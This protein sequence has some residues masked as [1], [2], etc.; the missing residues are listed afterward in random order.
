MAHLDP[1][2]DPC[3]SKYA[4]I[5]I[6]YS[7]NIPSSHAYVDNDLKSPEPIHLNSYD[8]ALSVIKQYI[9]QCPNQMLKILP[10][11]PDCAIRHG[12]CI[13]SNEFYDQICSTLRELWD[14]VPVLPHD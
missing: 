13:L 8:D 10:L 5:F 14:W 3:P 9:I 6:S 7:A 11:D 12:H 4:I 1:R 2:H